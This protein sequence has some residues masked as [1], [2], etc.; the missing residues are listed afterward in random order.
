MTALSER[1]TAPMGTL[2]AV[3]AKYG[4]VLIGLTFGLAAKY[5]LQLKKGVHIK[6]RSILADVLL[7]P[8][9][10]LIAYEMV[11]RFGVNGEGA[12]LI[13]AFCAVGA[14]RLVRLLSERFWRQIE[15]QTFRDVSREVL[16]SKGELRQAVQTV[17]SA[18][19]LTDTS[20][21]D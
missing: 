15:A 1:G 20:S 13:T 18:R 11:T 12:A 17:E 14:D 3:F 4:W 8:M 16:E 19:H 7:L 10:A 21:K 9:V 6:W 5:A 2:D